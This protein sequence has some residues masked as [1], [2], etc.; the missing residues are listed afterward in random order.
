M[1]GGGKG[2]QSTGVRHVLR[3]PAALMLEK[4]SCVAMYSRPTCLLAGNN[5]FK[6]LHF[7]Q[8]N[9]HPRVSSSPFTSMGFSIITLLL[10][11]G[12]SALVALLCYL[13]SKC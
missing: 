12:S 10:W 8:F 1:R 11:S 9:D 7:M 5:L 3:G 13:T 2:V 6:T 4:L